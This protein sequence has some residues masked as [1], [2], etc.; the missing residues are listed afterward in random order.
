MST[1]TVQSRK[2]IE[3]ELIIKAWKDPTF[4]KRLRENPKVTLEQHL[5]HTLPETVQVHVHDEDMNTFHIVL[6]PS[7]PVKPF[8]A[9]DPA[10][11]KTELLHIATSLTVCT[12][13]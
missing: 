9:V 13:C 11:L 1:A 6:P 12:V 4:K 10:P 7:S 5:G 2:D 3:Q 8:P